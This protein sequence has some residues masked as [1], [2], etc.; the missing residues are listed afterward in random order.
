MHEERLRVEA[1]T[2]HEGQAMGIRNLHK[3]YPGQVLGPLHA[4]LVLDRQPACI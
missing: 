4:Q 3:V 2:T 1:M